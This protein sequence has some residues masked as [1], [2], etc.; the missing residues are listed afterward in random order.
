M[1]HKKNSIAFQSHRSAPKRFPPTSGTGALSHQLPFGCCCLNFFH[2]LRALAPSSTTHFFRLGSCWWLAPFPLLKRTTR[3]PRRRSK[4]MARTSRTIEADRG[5]RR[6]EVNLL[7][8][9]F[10]IFFLLN[11]SFS[12]PTSR[13]AGQASRTNIASSRA[14]SLVPRDLLFFVVYQFY[15]IW[16]S[17]WGAIC[18]ISY[19]E[20]EG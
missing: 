17:D 4:G 2:T 19:L 11:C 12:M 16:P 3:R 7:N 20:K 5:N 18:D 1:R 6:Q 13:P 8:C 14:R 9:Y 15:F 10:L